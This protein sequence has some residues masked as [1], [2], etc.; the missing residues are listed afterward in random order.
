VSQL[1]YRCVVVV[2]A[3]FA[4]EYVVE[5]EAEPVDVIKALGVGA[6]STNRLISLLLDLDLLA[7]LDL[8]G[9]GAH[10]TT[11]KEVGRRGKT[12]GR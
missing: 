4:K 3:V 2:L 6:S 11:C 10:G 12:R 8:L 5:V 9:L 7:E 1:D